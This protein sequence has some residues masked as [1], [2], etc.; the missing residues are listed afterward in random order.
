MKQKIEN[1]ITSTNVYDAGLSAI[2]KK[3]HDNGF[4]IIVDCESDLKLIDNSD[5]KVLWKKNIIVAKDGEQF[6]IN[7]E[8]HGY[9]NNSLN[10]NL[11]KYFAIDDVMVHYKLFP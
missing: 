8:G 1:M 2:N 7:I 6:F 5:K 3:L 10:K 4:N 9:P 11:L